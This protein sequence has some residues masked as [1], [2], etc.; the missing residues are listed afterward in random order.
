MSA[1]KS[2]RRRL[3]VKIVTGWSNPGGSTVANINLCNLFNENNIDATLY[4]PHDWHLD[5]CKSG[6]LSEADPQEGDK[7][8]LHFITPPRKLP[9]AK[10]IL[11]CHETNLFP[12]KDID[13]SYYDLVHFVSNS[14]KNWHSVNHPS[15]IIPNV[16][17][18][19]VETRKSTKVAG[20]IGSIDRHKRTDLSIRRALDD[21]WE[22]VY[23]YGNVTDPE[24]F[25]TAVKPMLGGKVEHKGYCEQT[26]EMY[27][28]VD[29][30]YHSSERET[31]NYIQVE[32]D[33]TNTEYHGLDSNDPS[34][35]IWDNDRIVETWTKYLKL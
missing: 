28:S 27:D 31:F 18:E 34:S 35:D 13:L 32:C 6:V 16:L 7:L 22:K 15:V 17:N 25:S 10:I 19:L 21:G 2:W 5:K 8:I 11:S 1:S 4:G 26:Q 9:G 24:Y 14:Q 3:E 23:L 20:V 30:V 12:L 33:Q 29:S